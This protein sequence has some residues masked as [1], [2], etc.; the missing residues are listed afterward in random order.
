MAPAIVGLHHLA[1]PV[2]DA[3]RSSE[4]YEQ[5]FGFALLLVEEE[6]DRVAAVSLEH[7]CG[8]E[9]FLHQTEDQLRPW[10]EFA[11]FALEF[12]DQ[13]ELI[14]WERWL[15]SQHVDHSGVRP[16]H[17]GWALDVTDPDGSRIQLHTRPLL[18][19]DDR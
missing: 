6:E 18:T 10:R 12:P 15:T 3:L 7:P 8:I 14:R 13:P 5:V 17:L 9:L 4:W 19:S 2:R 11:A 1:V 16:A